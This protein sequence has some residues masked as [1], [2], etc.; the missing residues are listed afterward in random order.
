[1]HEVR[2]IQDLLSQI[3]RDE[4]LLPEFQRRYVWNKDQVR[5]LM[6]SL[7]RKHF[8]GDLLIWR[9]YRPSLANAPPALPRRFPPQRPSTR[10]TPECCSRPLAEPTRC[11]WIPS[12]SAAPIL[13]VSRTPF[14]RCTRATARKSACLTPCY[15]RLRNRALATGR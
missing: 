12:S 2:S 7:D 3:S 1:M 6:Q 10:S 11:G 15:W 14:P 5:G 13:F 9:T 4:I 8:T